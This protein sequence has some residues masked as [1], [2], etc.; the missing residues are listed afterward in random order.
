MLTF[1]LLG[2]PA[3]Q[4]PDTLAG[5]RALEPIITE[6]SR[7]EDRSSGSAGS[8]KAA[9]YI[10]DYFEN[11]GL[12]PQTYRFQVPVRQRIHASITVNGRSTDLQPLLNN[13]V[14]P[15]TTDGSLQ[16]PLFWVGSGSLQELDQKLIEKAILL[17][18]FNSGRSWLTAASLGASA[19]IFVDRG[20]TR[21]NSF[22]RE[23]E[24]LSPLQFP[25][26]WMEEAQ[27]RELFGDYTA[28]PNGLVS[29][30]AAISSQI[31]SGATPPRKTSTASSKEP[32]RNWPK[33]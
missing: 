20:V 27:A 28:M 13:A 31:L 33:S 4:P 21:V 18:D 24:E 6:L 3:I 14:T 29:D 16:G 5:E 12:S 25:C 17:M 15:Q 1:L 10:F 32:I 11:L 19:V 7:Y 26:F 23:K 30:Q 8:E 22:F 9:A 2:L